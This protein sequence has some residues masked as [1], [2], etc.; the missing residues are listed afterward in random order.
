MR[1]TTIR[2][3]RR[4][5][6]APPLLLALL[7]LL[8]PAAPASATTESTAEEAMAAYVDAFWDPEEKYFTTYSDGRGRGGVGPE[9]GRYSDFWWEGRLWEVV[10]DAWET[11]GDP[12]Y[13]AMIDDVYDGFTAH[14]PT[15]GS[16]FNDDVNW[17]A[18]GAAR[19]YE[20]T[21]DERYLQTSVE[22]FDRI[23]ADWDDTYGGGIWW[24]QSVQDQKNVATN[25]PAA[26]T[27]VALARHTG[28]EVY[29]ERA[30]LLFDWVDENLVEEDGHVHDHWEGEGTLVRWDFTYNFGTYIG[31]ATALH[32]VTGEQ[33]YLTKAVRSA[34]WVTTRLTNGGTFR[35]EG[36]GDGGGF[37]S[38][39]VRAL[40]DLVQEHG[41]TQYLEQLQDNATQAW[42]HRRTSD[43]LMGHDW[44]APTSSGPLQSLAASSGLTA[45]LLVPPDGVRGVL[46]E[47]GTYEAENGLVVNISSEATQPGWTG[48]GYLAGWNRDGQQVTLN[49]NVAKGGSH[50]IRFRYAGDDGDATRMVM[51]NSRVVDPRF[52][53]PGTGGW[54][55]WQTVDLKVPLSRGHNSIQV[56]FDEASDNQAYLNLDTVQ[57]L[58]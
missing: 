48:R 26:M 31:A 11:T 16:D 50:T 29:L 39:L 20:L 8:L 3:R 32:E 24:R 54:D 6:I 1:S 40:V 52:E 19:A 2:R 56:R 51:V 23:W 27:A 17:W 42:N 41:Q 38:L 10:M 58:R 33:E 15:F 53:F 4:H 37:K 34:D 9:G 14:Y 36:I 21:G 7:A 13:R 22:L 49:V 12:R 25:A 30:Q 47:S 18:M 45:V 35:N 44:S 5:L 46:A 28:E 43:D 57:L 55:D